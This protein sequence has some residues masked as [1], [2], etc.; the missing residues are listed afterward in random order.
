MGAWYVHPDKGLSE[1]VMLMGS[2]SDAQRRRP[3]TCEGPCDSEKTCSNIQSLV[4]SIEVCCGYQR[5]KTMNRGSRTRAIREC[6]VYVMDSDSWAFAKLVQEHAAIALSI[7]GI[8]LLFQDCLIKIGMSV[9]CGVV[10]ALGC[11]Q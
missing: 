6:G 11:H 1:S 4:A 9:G 7:R 8:L 2:S 3:V 10:V 5:L